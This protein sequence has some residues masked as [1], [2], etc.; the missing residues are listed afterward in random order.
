[1][2]SATTMTLASL[3]SANACALL[4]LWLRLRWRTRGEEV[5]RQSLRGITEAVAPG[6]QV[7]LD[8]Q[9]HDGHRIRM[10]ITRTPAREG[11]PAE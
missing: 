2:D 8:D 5:R 4:A 11:T 3:I 6:V 10:K 1:M 9:S 7:E